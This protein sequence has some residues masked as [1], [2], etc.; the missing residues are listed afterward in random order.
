VREFL[1]RIV[2]KIGWSVG[3]TGDAVD[4]LPRLSSRDLEPLLVALGPGDF[5]LLGNNG[6]LS[7]VAVHVGERRIVH[8]M[9]TEKTM[10]GWL[11]SLVDAFWR[12]FGVR[13]PNVGVVEEGLVGFL[14][15]FERDTWVLVRHP[16]LTAEER[17]RGLAHV[18]ALVG[19]PYD[20][21]FRDAN[22]ALYCTEI[23]IEFLRAALGARAPVL[24]TRR[25]RVPL[26]LDEQV[27][28]PVAVL[29][30]PD[31]R[32]VAGNDAARRNYAKQLTA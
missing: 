13:E 25:A 15:R 22:E 32:V 17:D 19:R 27:V 8:A 20:Y 18:R 23:V 29:D 1:L 7:H 24:A 14:E 10:R 5:V 31:L 30:H 12:M 3:G 6:L 2:L 9:A 28:E 26:L 4:G 21:G 11:G 16:T